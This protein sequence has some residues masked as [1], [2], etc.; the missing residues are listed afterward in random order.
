MLDLNR[1]GSG[2][3]RNEKNLCSGCMLLAPDFRLS[4][5]GFTC[6]RDCDAPGWSLNAKR[7]AMKRGV[8]ACLTVMLICSGCSLLDQEC[9]DDDA[10]DGERCGG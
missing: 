10:A 2:A 9:W 8:L 5:S 4:A 1:G 3:I 6:T 7:P